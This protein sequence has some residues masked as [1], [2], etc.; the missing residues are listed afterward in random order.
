MT[1]WDLV[2]DLA[3]TPIQ[4]F[5]KPDFAP[6]ELKDGKVYF[7]FLLSVHILKLFDISIKIFMLSLQ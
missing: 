4:D 5:Y 7:L 6:S 3:Y 2:L 1:L